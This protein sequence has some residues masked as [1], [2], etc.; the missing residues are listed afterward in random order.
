MRI[1]ID[2]DDDGTP[3]SLPPQKVN[4]AMGVVLEALKEIH[5]IATARLQD[6]GSVSE[7][8]DDVL[9]SILDVISEVVKFEDME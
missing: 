6:G 3:K 8:E 5:G 7:L 2:T 1:T 4:E 9:T